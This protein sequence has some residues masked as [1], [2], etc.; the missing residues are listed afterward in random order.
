MR[1]EQRDGESV[2]NYDVAADESLSQGVVRAVSTASNVDP[3]PDAGAESEESLD[4]LY[5]V[6]DPDALDAVFRTT[7]SSARGGQITFTYHG[8]EVTVHSEGR[9]SVERF[10]RATGEAAD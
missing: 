7:D 10:R 6:I 3:I 9:V 8:R 2:F 4:P 5:T 1:N